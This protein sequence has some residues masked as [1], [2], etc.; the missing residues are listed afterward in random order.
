[1]SL[2]KLAMDSFSKTLREMALKITDRRILMIEVS[3][4]E[5]RNF[6]LDAQGLRTK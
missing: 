5:A 1:V 4:E 3:P 2:S 6:I